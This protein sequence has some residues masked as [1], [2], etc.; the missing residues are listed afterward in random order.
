MASPTALAQD[1]G[2]GW[3]LSRFEPAPAGD[4]MFGVPSPYTAGELTP[5][6]MVLADYAHNPL[7][8]RRETDD[9]VV[10]AV[11]GDQ[12]VLH[13]GA[14]LAL[15][16]RVTVDV[17][18]PIAVLQSGDDPAAGGVGVASPSG[19]AL[20][21]LR[22]GARVSLLGQYHDPFQIAVGGAIWLPTGSRDAYL[23][24]GTIRAAPQLI[25]G[26]RIDALVWS[27]A[28]SPQFRPTRTV[29]GGEQGTTLQWGGG[30]GFLLAEGKL[31]VGPELHMALGL[32]QP[33]ATTFNSE[34]LLDAR[35]RILP[36]IEAGIGLGPGLTGAAGTPDFRG[37]GMVAWT[38]EQRRPRD[39]DGDGVSDER[40]A[41]PDL[42][43]VQSDEAAKNGCPAVKDRDRDGIGDAQ[44]AC[45][46][47]PG[48]QSAEV[49]KNGC[50]SDQDGDGIAD[51]QDACPEVPGVQSAEA[52][53]NGCPSD[54]DGDGIPDSKDACPKIPGP[55]DANPRHNG[56]PK[57]DKDQDGIPDAVDMCPNEKG[58]PSE[59]LDEYG[60]PK[61]LRVTDQE[62]RLLQQIQFDFDSAR[63]KPISDEILDEITQALKD[64]PEILHVE[65]QGHTDESGTKAYNRSLSQRRAEAVRQALIT[66]GVD[67]DRLS[68]KGY[69][70]DVPLDNNETDEGRQ[71]NRR[72][73]FKIVQTTTRK[74]QN[75]P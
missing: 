17:D 50:P 24:D 41:C 5:H 29:P 64:H 67:P 61:T 13:V 69:G 18:V 72:V 8:L 34:L 16:R 56:C 51:A 52:A 46:D 11:V 10:G 71:K 60:C 59:K 70:R 73:Q 38:S 62:V 44:D 4:R 47:L 28:A 74:P 9:E 14:A 48:V 25:V 22:L 75:Q 26:G 43:G 20:G 54:Q 65:V 55:P 19:G 7:V 27:L 36:D 40:D 32:T 39:G 23:S 6:V 58:Y 35:Y 42:P 53:K 1:A 21:D 66:R 45:P 30:V 63:I 12:L 15:W 37:V 3:A 49:A 2:Q 57:D 33:D 31:Q 68:A